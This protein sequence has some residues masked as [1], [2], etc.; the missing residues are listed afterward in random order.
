MVPYLFSQSF[1]NILFFFP[2]IFE[3]IGTVCEV[4]GLE[5][6]SIAI[7]LN[8]LFRLVFAL[9]AK[10]SLTESLS[11][12]LMFFKFEKRANLFV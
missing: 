8:F 3:I 2:A 6:E 9:G 1:L 12:L 10:F 4:D 11:I 5:S 7:L